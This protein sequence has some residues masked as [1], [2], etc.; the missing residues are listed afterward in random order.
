MNTPDAH[1]TYGHGSP[2]GT[3][4]GAVRPAGA[5]PHRRSANPLLAVGLWDIGLPIIAYYGLRLAGAAE[6]LALIAA[7]GTALLRVVWTLARERRIDA[8]AGLMC[9]V[10]AVG[11]GLSYVTGDERLVL[12]TKS[13]TTLAIA[14]VMIT[15]LIVRRPAAFGMA[16]RFGATDDAERANWQRMYDTVPAFRRV[17][18]VM[19]TVW[20][21]I[22]LIESIA[23]IPLIYLLPPDTAVPASYVLLGAAI[24]VSLTWAAWYGKRGAQR[25][26]HE[27]PGGKR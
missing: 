14:V 27:I 24:T 19:T 15:S 16:M 18:V 6:P 25:A 12:A 13:V 17:Y 20:A 7:A 22:L 9:L 11:L 2:V 1:T 3:E 26:E 21:V 10:F 5:T 4:P 8:F 23:R